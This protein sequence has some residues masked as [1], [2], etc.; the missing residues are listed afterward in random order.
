MKRYIRSSYTYDPWKN[1]DLSKWSD[2]DVDTWNTTDWKARNYDSLYVYDDSF[3][4]TLYI[5]GLPE[6]VVTE[7]VTFVK[8]LRANTIYSPKYVVP[9]WYHSDVYK[10]Y[11]ADGITLLT[12]SVERTTH[13]ADGVTYYVAD[14]AETQ[15]LYDMLSR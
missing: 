2:E 4:G 7:P 14:R 1:A 10:K 15:E 11:K 9:D 5:Y 12:P 6:G 8:E 3:V 13:K